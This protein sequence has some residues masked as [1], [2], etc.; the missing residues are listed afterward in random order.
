[1]EALPYNTVDDTP[2][3]DEV[4]EEIPLNVSNLFDP[5]AHVEHLVAITSEISGA[6]INFWLELP[7]PD[8]CFNMILHWKRRLVQRNIICSSQNHTT[9]LIQS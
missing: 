5:R 2:G 9:M 1:M 3:K 7:H 4:S 6:A 8:F